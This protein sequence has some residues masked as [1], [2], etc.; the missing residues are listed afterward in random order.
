MEEEVI[1]EINEALKII[2]LNSFYYK[3]KRHNNTYLL[4]RQE[5]Y[6]TIKENGNI[7][8]TTTI[9]EWYGRY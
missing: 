1:L 8:L 4:D 3:F 7:I 9:K 6:L 2:S 5:N